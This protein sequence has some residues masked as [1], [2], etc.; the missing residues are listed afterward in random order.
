MIE[1]KRTHKKNTV[2]LACLVTAML[3]LSA[4]SG[5]ELAG[6]DPA[7]PFLGYETGA[8]VE[9]KKDCPTFAD[10]CDEL[11]RTVYEACPDTAGVDPA[12][13]ESCKSKAFSQALNAIAGCF[14]GPEYKELYDCARDWRPAGVP[15]GEDG[16][17][18]NLEDGPPVQ[19]IGPKRRVMD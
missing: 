12:D 19:E 14:T 16:A 18:R 13:L 15:P 17:G 6:P 10:A 7:E 9:E 2:L 5:S 8:V 3:T 11:G 4:C 1:M